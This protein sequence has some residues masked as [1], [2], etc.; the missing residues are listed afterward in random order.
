MP[1]YEYSCTECH[2]QTEILQKAQEQ[3]STTCPNCNQPSFT[4]AISAPRFRLGG[5]GW[6]ETDEKKK[7]KQRYIKNREETTSSP[8]ESA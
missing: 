3:I 6:Y 7:E 1:I 5:S 2:H 4:K 8:S